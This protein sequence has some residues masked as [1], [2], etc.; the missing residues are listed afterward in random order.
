[1]E[2]PYFCKLISLHFNV[3]LSSN[4]LWINIAYIIFF[5]DPIVKDQGRL[6][7]VSSSPTPMS[8]TGPA[9]E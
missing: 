9:G 4:V 2:H 3:D 1:M 7:M 6:N 8:G 5:L